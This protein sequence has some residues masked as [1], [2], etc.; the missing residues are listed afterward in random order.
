M[1][2]YDLLFGNIP[3]RALLEHLL[4]CSKRFCLIRNVILSTNDLIV[5]ALV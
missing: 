4:L 2:Q 5:T 1:F 3:N